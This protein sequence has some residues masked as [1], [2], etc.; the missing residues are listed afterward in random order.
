MKRSVIIF[1]LAL[2]SGIM[3]LNAVNYC[4][5]SSW[6]Y[7]GT[8][9]TGGGN[10]TPIL[11]STYDEL[12]RALTTETNQPKVIIIT[13]DIE[14]HK[15]IV[16]TLSNLTLLA[17]PGVRL[18]NNEKNQ[19]YSG[20]FY[21]SEGRNIII[22]NITFEGPGAF[23]CDGHDN[24]SFYKV[25]HAWVDHCDFQD[26]IDGNLDIHD[27]SDSITVSW[28]RFRYLKESTPGGSHSDDHRFS[29][30]IGSDNEDIPIDGIYN[31][32]HAYCWW[33]EGC[34]QRMT[35]CRHSELHFLNCYWNSSVSDYYIGPENAS[36]YIEGGT[37]E[38]RANTLNKVWDPYGT[39]SINYCTFVNCAG[40]IPADEGTVNA[41]AYPYDHLTAAEAKAYVTDP[42]CGA[43]ATLLV[44]TYGR[45]Y[46]PC[47]MPRVDAVFYW[48]MSGSEAPANG[49]VLPA[50]GG[51][52][53]VGSTKADKSFAVE[54]A[55]YAAS[56]PNY[57]KAKDGKGLKNTANSEYL[58]LKLSD[59]PFLA[60]DT[61]I[62]C[63]YLPWKISTSLTSGLI[64]S[65]QTGTAKTD[66]N[67][68]QLILPADADSLVLTRNR[69]LGTGISTIIVCRKPYEKPAEKPDTVLNSIMWNISDDDFK[70]LDTIK[71]DIAIR[72]LHL[73]ATGQSTMVVDASSK[74]L[75]GY[76][77]THR[78]KT[79]GTGG[80]DLRHVWFDV[81]GD[82]TIDI[83]V[84]S[85]NSEVHTVNIA[86]GTFDN[87]VTTV[88]AAAS[89]PAKQTYSYM[90]GVN[91]I[92]LSSA[93]A[94][95]NFYGIKLSYQSSG[96]GVEEASVPL[97][98]QTSKLLRNG[99]ILIRR[100]DRTFTLTGTEVK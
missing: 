88:P 69:S 91:R 39:S 28:C 26:G 13:Q 4:A 76:H 23:D 14:F 96:M 65:V 34:K 22:R 63:G 83:Y 17:L 99:Q 32:T 72:Q 56:V 81:K 59:G 85:A 82:C 45:V 74:N 37:F 97:E 11:V 33:D 3:S 50:D 51:S 31:V 41:P 75:D 10:A 46:S 80:A 12:K 78:L 5:P 66:Y 89:N 87:V 73:V 77:F 40:N 68:G 38:G 86:V 71:T 92:Y 67:I 43:G 8:N 27:G 16:S 18:I 47:E 21:F 9:V 60:G 49:S 19:S 62:L 30:L 25:Y 79:R 48:Q 1:L 44:N 84:S 58:T 100:A 53:Y 52:V 98:L 6:G 35:R 15:Y 57:M 55:S 54:P 42:S 20:F 7:A 2:I 90:G 36:C 70:N 61:L 29:N 93:E 95:I 94:G 64:D 24:L